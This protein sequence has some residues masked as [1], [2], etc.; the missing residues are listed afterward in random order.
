M[1]LTNRPPESEDVMVNETESFY[2]VI[3]VVVFL[4]AT[5]FFPKSGPKHR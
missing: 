1:A 3:A 5:L 2:L 4:V